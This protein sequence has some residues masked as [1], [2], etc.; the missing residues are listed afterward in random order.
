MPVVFRAD[1]I[2]EIVGADIETE[3]S[4]CGR[5]LKVGIRLAGFAGC[6]G[7]D[8]LAKAF[9]PYTYGGRKYRHGADA[10]RERGVIARKGA[11]CKARHNMNASHF[12]FRLQSDLQTV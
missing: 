10:I 8:C 12:R 3:C 9:A 4:H 5:G 1:E 2:V 7:A 11:E 6:F